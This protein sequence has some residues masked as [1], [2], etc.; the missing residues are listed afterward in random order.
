M[1]PGDTELLLLLPPVLCCKNLFLK[2]L[3]AGLESVSDMVPRLDI[4]LSQPTPLPR[5]RD[6]EYGLALEGGSDS[7]DPGGM[8]RT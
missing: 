4:L 2:C 6:G 7:C 8:F 5:C 1:C 3:G